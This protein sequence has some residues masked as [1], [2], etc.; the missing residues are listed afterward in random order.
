[1][2]QFK[3][4]RE[5]ADLTQKELA[6]LAGVSVPVILR[7]E[8]GLRV[9]QTSTRAVE[10]ALSARREHEV[11]AAEPK[12]LDQWISG[13]LKHL[14]DEVKRVASEEARSAIA[15]ALTGL[16]VEQQKPAVDSMVAYIPPP[17]STPPG[18]APDAIITKYNLPLASGVTGWGI[19]YETR[20]LRD[21]RKLPDG[22]RFPAVASLRRFAAHGEQYSGL[23]FKKL[24]YS[25]EA[26]QPEYE[27][28]INR[29]YR[30]L[31]RR[32]SAEKYYTMLR[33][34]SHDELKG[35]GA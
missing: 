33:I 8:K 2:T 12:T 15:S 26:E 34:V 19:R 17:P 21:L 1:M 10:Q 13:A 5:A 23:G 30:I 22:L 14:M 25:R 11:Q 6:A 29:G 7:L 4:L 9:R 27:F 16:K 20:F 28:R 24:M 18:L 32:D 31:V 35:G 3:E